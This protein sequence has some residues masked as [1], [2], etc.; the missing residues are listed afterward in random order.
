ML[1]LKNKKVLVLSVKFRWQQNN[2]LIHVNVNL[3]LSLNDLL[4]SLLSSATQRYCPPLVL[5]YTHSDFVNAWS[6]SWEHLN[7]TEKVC[8]SERCRPGASVSA[9]SCLIC[10]SLK[11]YPAS[12][13][14]LFWSQFL[15]LVDT[16]K[17]LFLCFS[18]FP[19]CCLYRADAFHGCLRAHITVATTEPGWQKG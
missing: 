1:Q 11:S 18:A 17:Q 13:K 12:S 10:R 3:F 2:W 16:I 19:Q 9:G 14:V 15:Q 8:H 5:C 4:I 6:V 7:E